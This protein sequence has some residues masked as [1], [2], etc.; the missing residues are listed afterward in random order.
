MPRAL[1]Q[2]DCLMITKM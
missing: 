2:N 1:R